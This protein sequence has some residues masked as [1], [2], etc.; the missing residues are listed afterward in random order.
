MHGSLAKRAVIYRTR[1]GTEAT[2]RVA[3]HC[4]RVAAGEIGDWKKEIALLGDTMNTTARIE[5]AAREFG[6]AT[7]LSDDVVRRLPE[8]MRERL[9]PLPAYAAAGKQ[10]VLRLWATDG[11]G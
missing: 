5:S 10:D 3:I 8:E 1:Y 4:G 11:T 7:V 2:I 6:T 9:R